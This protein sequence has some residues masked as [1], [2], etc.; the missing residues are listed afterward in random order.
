MPA[1]LGAT[2]TFELAEMAFDKGSGLADF[3]KG[4]LAPG[5]M[6]VFG[7]ISRLHIQ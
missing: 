3:G 5:V 7:R 4:G 1:G 6:P 2:G